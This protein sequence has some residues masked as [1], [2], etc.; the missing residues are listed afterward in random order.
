MKRTRFILSL[1]CLAFA[2]TST[3]AYSAQADNESKRDSAGSAAAKKLYL[4]N[5]ATYMDPEILKAFEEKYNVDVV[6]SFFTDN[7]ELFAKL[8]AGGVS[9]YDVVFPSS[10]YVPRLA[11]TGLIRPFNMELI[12]NYDNLLPKFDNP[13]YD[14][15]G[16]DKVYSVA[17]QWGTT[18][19]GYDQSVFPKPPESWAFIFD[20]DV[21]PKHPFSMNPDA[22]FMLGAACAYLGYDYTCTKTG[23]RAQLKEAAQLILKTKQRPNFSGFVGGN[24]ANRQLARG[25]IEAGVVWNGALLG[26]KQRNPKAYA[27]IKFLL[28]EEGTEIWVDTMAIPADAPHPKLAHKFINFILK[29]KIGAQLANWNLYGSPNEAAGPYLDKA[30]TEPPIQ[31]TKHQMEDALRFTPAIKGKRLK[32]VQQL[33]AAIMS[34]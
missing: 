12:P 13:P 24:P 5:W 2:I 23:T 32:F 14:P 30:L 19:I 10:Y 17:Y 21:N 18:G 16:A 6:R 26:E 20:P 22:Q 33:W 29:P 27:N 31:P 7:A 25:N 15:G 34:Q 11:E 1:V 8:R 9:Q 28:P 3:A 4:F